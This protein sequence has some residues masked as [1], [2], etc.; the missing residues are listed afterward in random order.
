MPARVLRIY[1]DYMPRNELRPATLLR[2]GCHQNLWRDFAGI[3]A[4]E[5]LQVRAILIELRTQNGNH[6]VYPRAL[7]CSRIWRTP[8]A[9]HTL[10]GMD[11]EEP[12]HAR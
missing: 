6:G 8:R 3:G 11:P 2:I 4:G 9:P 7:F 1:H 10:P 5:R 12:S